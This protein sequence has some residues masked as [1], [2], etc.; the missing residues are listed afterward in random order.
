[1]VDL[2]TLAN[3]LAEKGKDE[4]Y[5]FLFEVNPIPGEIEVLQVVVEDKEELPIF[6]SVSED[7]ILC[8]AYLFRSE[9]L[10]KGMVDEMN[11]AMLSANISI[12]L[13]S[14]ALLEDQYVIYGA[15]SVHSSL[16]DIVHELEVLSSNTI[17]AIDAMSDYLN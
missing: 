17:E 6:L 2:T 11:K 16:Q 9:E 8:I 3:Q 5:G 4:Q 13:S 14:F 12:P 1:M 7:Q 10:K 15:L